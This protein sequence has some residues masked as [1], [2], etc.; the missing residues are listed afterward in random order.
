[1]TKVTRTLD[2]DTE[3]LSYTTEN[4]DFMAVIQPR[5]ATAE[6]INCAF[7]KMA[8]ENPNIVVGKFSGINFIKTKR[9]Y[10]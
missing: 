6:E 2:G 5:M 1:M 9:R 8:E 3:M 4:G 10:K 7:A